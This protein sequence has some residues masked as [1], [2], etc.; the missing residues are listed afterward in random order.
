MPLSPMSSFAPS[1]TDHTLP[2]ILYQ[3][4]QQLLSDYDSETAAFVAITDGV[5]VPQNEQ[6]QE[7]TGSILQE[8]GRSKLRFIWPEIRSK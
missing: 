1:I 6:N 7:V 5:A 4:V 3:D 8:Q 2:T